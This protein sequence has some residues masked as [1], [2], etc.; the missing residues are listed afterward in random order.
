[1][2]RWRDRL[3][4]PIPRIGLAW[5]GSP[6]HP[7]DRHR[8]VALERLA[9]LL[10]IRASFVSLQKELREP[11]RQWLAAH[12]AI[13]HFGDEFSD[14]ADTAALISL[15]DLVISVDTSAAHLAGALDV[16]V[17][18]MVYGEWR[19]LLDRQDSPWYPR[20]RLFRQG[21]AGDWDSVIAT[22]ARELRARFGAA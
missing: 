17:W 11:D 13:S 3:T 18:I 10:E 12:P 20:A 2:R 8:S 9:P 6:A 22:V 4:A 7:H 16:P 15:C 21:R 5:S 14:F 19:W 1:V